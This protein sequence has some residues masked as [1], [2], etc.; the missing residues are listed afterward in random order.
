ML[1]GLS[2]FEQSLWILCGHQQ[3]RSSRAGRRAA[4][5]F[6]F[7]Q[8]AHRYT[9][10]GSKLPLREAGTFTNGS[11]RWNVHDAPNLAAVGQPKIEINGAAIPRLWR[12]A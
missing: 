9:K 10:Q 11:Y 5:L 8:C 6:P 4:P 2:N 1:S 3:Q 12:R 7:L